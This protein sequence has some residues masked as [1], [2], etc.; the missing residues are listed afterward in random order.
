LHIT[1]LT[2]SFNIWD[3]LIKPFA[4]ADFSESREKEEKADEMAEKKFAG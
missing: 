2:E 4:I 3:V 1:C